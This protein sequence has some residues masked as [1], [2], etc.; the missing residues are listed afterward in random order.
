MASAGH[1]KAMPASTLPC[2]KATA[3]AVMP[4]KTSINTVRNT[5]RLNMALSLFRVPSFYARVFKKRLRR[6]Y[7]A[8]LVI[9][10]H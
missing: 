6:E 1:K 7:G 9:I 2:V 3:L 5:A 8:G 10:Y 4:D